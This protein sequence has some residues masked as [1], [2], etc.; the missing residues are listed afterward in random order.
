MQKAISR[1]IDISGFT[2][3]DFAN[4]SSD[5][6]IYDIFDHINEH[7]FLI[8][9]SI[10]TQSRVGVDDVKN[11]LDQFPKIRRPALMMSFGASQRMD[12]SES[13][14]TTLPAPARPNPT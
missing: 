5:H 14:Q 6:T 10:P 13:A 4:T 12:M 8:K 1:H 9:L 11:G 2:I 3:F 7:K